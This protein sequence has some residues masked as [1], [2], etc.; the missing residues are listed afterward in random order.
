MS[1]IDEAKI[2]LKNIAI[3]EYYTHY[4]SNILEQVN[5]IFTIAQ[6]ARQ[7]GY[8]VTN[9][10][11][12]KIAY[13]LADRVAKMHNIEIADRLRSLLNFTTKE[14]AALKIAEE[15]AKGEYG[16]GDLKTRLENAVRVSL[17][18]V[19]EGV[20]VAPLQGISDVQIK[21]N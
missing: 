18:V 14:K 13:D 17:A 6:K 8:D 4:H 9:Y 3:P 10:I 12:S 7:K 2:R 1:L 19:T 20:T 11:E 21:S 15:I 16:S 5:N